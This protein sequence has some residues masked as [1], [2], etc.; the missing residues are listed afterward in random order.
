MQCR[1]N[2]Y[3]A[4]ATIQSGVERARILAHARAHTYAAAHAHTHTC[5]QAQTHAGLTR[6]RAGTHACA[7][8]CALTC[9]LTCSYCSSIDAR[10]ACNIATCA[11]RCSV[12]TCGAQR[13]RRSATI[14]SATVRRSACAQRDARLVARNTRRVCRALSSHVAPL[15]GAPLHDA[16]LA[17]LHVAP[18]RSARLLLDDDLRLHV[19]H[20][21][22]Q[23]LELRAS[24]R[25]ARVCERACVCARTAAS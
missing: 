7:R 4:G 20:L 24:A 3:N 15:H 23:V 13:A 19:E 9:C 14:Q 1:C 25:G 5:T 2:V 16:P 22:S 21:L 17:P 10:S 11:Q 18:L 6:T 12:Q 8:T